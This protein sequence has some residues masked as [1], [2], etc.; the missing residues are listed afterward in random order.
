MYHLMQQA[1]KTSSSSGRVSQSPY[2]GSKHPSAMKG[3][4]LDFSDMFVDPKSSASPPRSLTRRPKKNGPSIKQHKQDAIPT[5]SDLQKEATYHE[6]ISHT[7]NQINKPLPK[8]GAISDF[9]KLNHLQQRTIAHR[10]CQAVWTSDSMQRIRSSIREEIGKGKLQIRDDRDLYVDLTMRKKILSILFS[11][12]TDWLQLGLETMFKEKIQTLEKQGGESVRVLSDGVQLPRKNDSGP[13][14]TIR[15]FIIERLLKDDKVAKKH[16]GRCRVPSHKFQD[17]FKEEIKALVLYR[18]FILIFFLDRVVEEKVLPSRMFCED[19]TFKST[20]SVLQSFSREFLSREGDVVKHLKKIGLEVFYEG[21]REYNIGDMDKSGILALEDGTN[22]ARLCEILTGYSYGSILKHLK[23]PAVK[24]PALSPLQNLQNVKLV[25]QVFEEDGIE[26]PENVNASRIVERKPGTVGSLVMTLLLHHS[27]FADEESMT[28]EISGI[29]GVSPQ[30]L[31]VR[32]KLNNMQSKKKRIQALLVAWCSFISS[33]HYGVDFEDISQFDGIVA[34]S[35]IHYHVPR[36][37]N[38]DL[39]L[40]TSRKTNFTGDFGGSYKELF[41]NQRQNC[42]LANDGLSSIGSIGRLVPICDSASPLDNDAVL[43]FLASAYIHLRKCKKQEEG[44]SAI[45]R[46]YRFKEEAKRQREGRAASRIQTGWRDRLARHS[47]LEV[48][49]TLKRNK[50]REEA[51]SCIL[52]AWIGFQQVKECKSK[53][54]DLKAQRQNALR[55]DSADIIRRAWFNWKRIQTILALSAARMQA[56]QELSLRLLAEHN[57]AS[58]IQRAFHAWRIIHAKQTFHA[59]LIQSRWRSFW[60]Q[61]HFHIDRFDVVAVQS[62][63]RRF[64]AR[65]A[66]Q[67]RMAAVIKIQAA[68]RGSQARAI[69]K[70]ILELRRHKCAI[71]I[72][73]VARLYQVQ[74]DVFLKA[75]A[76]TTIQRVWRGFAA[77]SRW[78]DFFFDDDE[79]IVQSTQHLAHRIAAAN[80]IR[81]A[82]IDHLATRRKFADHRTKRK[83]FSRAAV[84]AEASESSDNEKTILEEVQ[85]PRSDEVS[86][87][88]PSQ[89]QDSQATFFKDMVDS[90]RASI[91]RRSLVDSAR[92]SL[93]RKLLPGLEELMV[94]S[95][96]TTVT[97]AP[98]DSSASIPNMILLEDP[99]MAMYPQDF[100]D[101]SDVTTQGSRRRRRV[102]FDEA[103]LRQNTRRK[104]N[105]DEEVVDCSNCKTILCLGSTSDL[106]DSERDDDDFDFNYQA[107]AELDQSWQGMKESKCA[108]LSSSQDLDGTW[109]DLQGEWKSLRMEE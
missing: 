88:S 7:I 99:E 85:N 86:K 97:T 29:L 87:A 35:I 39:V 106:V 22:L 72:Q 27:L 92:A 82:W 69:V 65:I 76:T 33:L 12:S 64:L 71:K 83:R 91:C 38:V 51:Y 1:S 90:A 108:T 96:S 43:L 25:L 15:K 94:G 26:F 61:I 2:S 28:K 20:R 18:I 5:V 32:I 73:S 50:E 107:F 16:G 31:K 30:E 24:F 70:E 89:S 79:V 58:A 44:T 37:L 105:E 81:V 40:P 66:F 3:V 52:N 47:A 98:D 80:K 93:C 42:T 34:C 14:A 6:W 36:V 78:M 21:S 100:L 48:L 11:Y 23:F 62:C 56:Q 17:K 19:S 59:T 55:H 74:R 109:Q 45:Q 54:N 57:A 67:K 101:I 13:K 68:V 60:A 95:S 46:L 77:R 103:S 63:A 10:K 4:S 9:Q 102:S 84:E 75:F 8:D 53:L 104:M 41:S 49:L